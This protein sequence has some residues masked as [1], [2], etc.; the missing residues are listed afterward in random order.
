VKAALW[1]RDG[2]IKLRERNSL[3]RERIRFLFPQGGTPGRGWSPRVG[4]S[5]C[6]DSR[7]LAWSNDDRTQEK[8]K[9]GR[10]VVLDFYDLLIETIILTYR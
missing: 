8:I 9:D 6:T 7:W 3:Q 2:Y 10:H 1:E 5:R 4:L